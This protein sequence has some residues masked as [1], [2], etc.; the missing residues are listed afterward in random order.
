[1]K[2]SKIYS[3]PIT[4]TL[5]LSATT[6]QIPVTIISSAKKYLGAAKDFVVN[7]IPAAQLF[8]FAAIGYYVFSSTKISYE[9]IEAAIN[10]MTHQKNEADVNNIANQTE[11]AI[12]DMD[13]EANIN[14]ATNSSQSK[15]SNTSDN[16]SYKRTIE[17]SFRLNSNAQ[18][19]LSKQNA[20]GLNLAHQAALKAN[21]FALR[22]IVR[23]LH[24]NYSNTLK[25]IWKHPITN[26]ANSLL[27]FTGLDKLPLVGDRTMYTGLTAAQINQQISVEGEHKGKTVT[28]LAA[29]TFRNKQDLKELEEMY[30]RGADPSIEDQNGKTAT[31]LAFENTQHEV[32][33]A[34]I[35]ET[36]TNHGKHFAKPLNRA[37]DQDNTRQTDAHF[38]NAESKNWTIFGLN[39]GPNNAKKLLTQEDQDG[40]QP[41]DHAIKKGNLPVIGRLQDN[42]VFA[43]N[44]QAVEV[45]KLVDANINKE[46]IKIKVRFFFIY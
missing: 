9:N 31:D 41:L 14:N 42:K 39:I 17:E 25:D 20:E 28:H 11:E 8:L 19:L 27:H 23:G 34:Q 13:N 46:N 44:E 7:S 6:I 37:I 43:K 2:L 3:N 30:A 29:S 21:F 10:D 16:N 26:F 15:T 4:T 24:N 5:M 38:E 12:N 36:F 32:S 22:V 1:M 35:I 45:S 40:T 33:P 18:I